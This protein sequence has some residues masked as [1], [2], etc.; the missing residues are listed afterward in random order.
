MKLIVENANSL[1]YLYSRERDGIFVISILQLYQIA[2]DLEETPEPSSYNFKKLKCGESQWQEI[3][4][5]Q[6]VAHFVFEA[7]SYFGFLYNKQLED[8]YETENK[9]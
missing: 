6:K 8:P 2:F 3:K 9:V 4:S 1:S 7:K 5:K